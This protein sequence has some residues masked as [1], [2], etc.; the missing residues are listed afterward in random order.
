MAYIRAFKKGL[1]PDPILSITKWS[2]KYRYLAKEG[3]K[4]SGLYRSSR[5]P[6]MIEIMNALS[7][8][9]STQKII[10][11]KGTQLGASE[12][13]LNFMFATSDMYPAPLLCVFP[14]DALAKQCSKKKI[15]P[16]I[17]KMPRL[18]NKIKEPKSRDSGNTILQKDFPGGSI[19][20]SGSNSPASARSLSVR[21]LVLDDF[22]GFDLDIG[23]EGSPA[24]LFAKR[25]DSFGNK[26]K[27][28]INSTPT[29]KGFSNIEKEY[30]KSSRG[31]WSVPCP[32]CGEYQYLEWGGKGFDY[33][34]KF[35]HDDDN[36]ILDIWYI[37]KHCKQ[38]I[39]ES[40]KEFMNSNGK[41]IHEFP[42]RK[43][44]GFKIPSLY[45]PLGWLSWEQMAEEFLAIGKSKEKLKVF[46][47]TRLAE[48][49]EEDGDQPDWVML[50]KRAEPYQILTVPNGGL[51]LTMG[52]DTQ[53]NR[54]VTVIR[55]WGK[56][57]E[58]WLVY[59]GELWGDP[60]QAD[61]WVQHDQL[62]SRGYGKSDGAV[63]NIMSAAIDTG[64]HKTQAVYNY[65]RTRAP[66][67]FAIKGSSQPG[68][69]VIGRPSTQDITWQGEKITN[70][71]QLWPLGVDTAKGIIYSRLKLSKSGAGCYH[72]PIGTEDD[73]YL[74]LTAEKQITRYIKG[75]PKPEW[76]KIR[77][78]ND[79]L[80]AEIY[81]YCA[82]MR[83]GMNQWNW[84]KVALPAKNTRKPAIRKVPRSSFMS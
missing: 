33:G 18:R 15:A 81:A 43:I 80:D 27:I 39:N 44:K 47:N 77:P 5:T 3:S 49:F 56:F 4:E 40:D 28:Y 68:R 83:M 54:L 50:K 21:Y 79:Y 35:K 82:A 46:V 16:A 37:C 53:D 76:V 30:V 6:W 55:A 69:P 31:L 13:A 1:R 42:N 72:W 71:V 36:L 70:G 23:G 10:V 73:Y 11:M 60:D 62:L 74:Q 32:H 12:V 67:V 61:V 26:K 34:I 2:D 7:P 51:F 24:D 22:D 48:T 29:I 38:R 17:K 8:S 57:E 14:T 84:D 65:C 78:R 66:V 64:G 52:T 59:Y 45:S 58:S 9:S 25:T 41:Y 19:T 75:F 63:L 20:L